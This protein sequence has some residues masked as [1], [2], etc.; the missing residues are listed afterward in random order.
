[1]LQVLGRRGFVKQPVREL[2]EPPVRVRLAELGLEALSPRSP[3]FPGERL[4]FPVDDLHRFPSRP[5]LDPLATR[6]SAV[7]HPRC[8]QTPNDRVHIIARGASGRR[9]TRKTSLPWANAITGRATGGGH[10]ASIGRPPSSIEV[11]TRC[12]SDRPRRES[13]YPSDVDEVEYRARSHRDPLRLARLPRSAK[14]TTRGDHHDDRRASRYRPT[15][16]PVATRGGSRRDRSRSRCSAPAPEF[17]TL[18]AA[19]H[20]PRGLASVPQRH[21]VRGRWDSGGGRDDPRR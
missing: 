15:A 2:R 9:R 20:Y 8:T 19:R 11:V 1:M 6:H 12:A 16:A 3:F 14:A 10:P 21:P 7:D 5:N 4:P 13:K 18:I 17:H